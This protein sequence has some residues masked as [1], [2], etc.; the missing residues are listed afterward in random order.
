[1]HQKWHPFTRKSSGICT[2][3]AEGRNH[4]A[5]NPIQAH[6]LPVGLHQPVIRVTPVLDFDVAEAGSCSNHL[7]IDQRSQPNWI[8]CDLSSYRLRLAQTEA[9]RLAAC[10]LRFRVFNLELGEG[11]AESYASGMD[12]DAFDYVCE[13]LVVEEKA[14]G[15]IVGTYRMQSGMTAR[16][17][18][19]YY[20]AREFDFTPYEHLRPQTLE[21]GRACIDREHRTSEVLTLLWRGIAQYAQHHGLRYLIGCSSVNSQ[22]TAQD[23]AAGWSI[24]DQLSPFLA[25]AALRTVPTAA[26]AL[27][28]PPRDIAA[29]RTD[30]SQMAET[31][32]PQTRVPKLLRTYLA[33]GSRI[34]SEPAWDR[35]FGTIDFLTLQDMEQLSPAA[36]NRFLCRQ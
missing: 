16:R 22:G 28:L 13:H 23:P 3:F 25:D 10:R 21:L 8:G 14:T 2:I 19:G 17:H 33:V 15:R 1:M 32:P 4:G 31:A 5:V 35:A 12:Q 36:R 7:Q 30:V 29:L 27:P 20:S 26:F 24:Y 34:C 18:L 11:L 6:K 9:E